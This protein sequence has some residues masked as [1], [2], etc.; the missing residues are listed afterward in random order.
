MAHMGTGSFCTFELVFVLIIVIILM[1][2]V[3]L[4]AILTSNTSQF[5]TYF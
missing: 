5:S 4:N 1:F 3:G 2:W